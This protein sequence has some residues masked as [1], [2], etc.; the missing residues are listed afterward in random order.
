MSQM[1]LLPR[2]PTQY[3][4]SVSNPIDSESSKDPDYASQAILYTSTTGALSLL[5]PLSPSVFRTL[6]ALQ[7]YLTTTL[8]HFLGL[9]PR[10]FRN[11]EADLSVGGRAIVDGNILKRWME[12]GSWKRSE[13]VSRVGEDGEWAVRGALESVGE[14]GLMLL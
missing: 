7:S 3:E 11:V 13:G 6:S 12:L 9:N 10:A 14:Q 5:T 8:P 1:T 2:E 4:L